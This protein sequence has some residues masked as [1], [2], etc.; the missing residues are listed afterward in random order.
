MFPPASSY[1]ENPLKEIVRLEAK[2]TS[3]RQVGIFP[4]SGHKT[5]D[6][7][8]VELATIAPPGQT[9]GVLSAHLNNDNALDLANKNASPIYYLPTAGAGIAMGSDFFSG[10]RIVAQGHECGQ[11]R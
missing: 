9:E 2:Q 8:R 10:A 7:S 4:R 5:G 11:S 3:S 6:Y 1:N